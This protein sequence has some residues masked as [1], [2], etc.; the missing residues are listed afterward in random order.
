MVR[1]KIVIASNNTFRYQTRCFSKMIYHDIEEDYPQC[2]VEVVRSCPSLTSDEYTNL[3]DPREECSEVEVMRCQILKRKVRHGRP[4]S[5]CSRLPSKLCA[6]SRCEQ[7]QK[8]CYLVVK[9]V[10]EV[11]PEEECQVRKKRICQKSEESD[12]SRR[13]RRVCRQTGLTRDRLQTDC[14]DRGYSQP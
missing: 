11:R 12:C 6:K 13:V 14:G 7:E 9:M 4:H 5:S 1:W 8:K 3:V 2:K 10:K